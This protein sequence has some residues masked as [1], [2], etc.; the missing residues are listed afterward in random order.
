MLVYFPLLRCIGS[1]IPVVRGTVV[2]CVPVIDVHAS[3]QLVCYESFVLAPMFEPASGNQNRKCIF[4]PRVAV[5][6]ILLTVEP[7]L[8]SV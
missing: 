8:I 6:L 1:S 3:P 4:L 7:E 5:T 2:Q